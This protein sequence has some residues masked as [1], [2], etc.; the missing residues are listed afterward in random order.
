MSVFRAFPQKTYIVSAE[1]PE[2]VWQEG[3]CSQVGLTRKVRCTSEHSKGHCLTSISLF[4]LFLLVSWS[5]LSH[6][7]TAQVLPGARW[8]VTH[9][10]Q[11]GLGMHGMT[12][13]SEVLLQPLRLPTAWAEQ[14]SWSHPSLQTPAG[15]TSQ[16]CHPCENVGV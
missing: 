8:E 9:P 6:M 10:F 14:H 13:S 1:I 3:G 11:G 4:F 12:Y 16:L 5:S 7:E 2:K 15:N